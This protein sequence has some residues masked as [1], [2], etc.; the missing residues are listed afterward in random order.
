MPRWML[1]DGLGDPTCVWSIAMG[2]ENGIYGHPPLEE[3]YLETGT[4]VCI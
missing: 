2:V 4:G 3:V 1:S